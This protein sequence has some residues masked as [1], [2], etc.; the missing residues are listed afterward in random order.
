M[1]VHNLLRQLTGSKPEVPTQPSNGTVQDLV[2]PETTPQTPQSTTPTST[3]PSVVNLQGSLCQVPMMGAEQD[4][5]VAS[6]GLQTGGEDPSLN[7]CVGA[8]SSNGDARTTG[9]I[10]WDHQ[11]GNGGDETTE[12]P[13]LPNDEEE[14]EASLGASQPVCTD[15]GEHCIINGSLYTREAAPAVS[16]E[17]PA[18]VDDTQ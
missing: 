17:Q 11:F 18:N 15:D 13:E 4:Q 10:S 12:T 14:T 7:V 1:A 2:T 16:A 9:I 5:F 3:R 6:V 8:T